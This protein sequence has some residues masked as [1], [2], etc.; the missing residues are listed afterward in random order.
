M[1]IIQ[2][3]ASLSKKPWSIVVIVCIGCLGSLK[4]EEF[5][6]EAC[7]SFGRAGNNYLMAGTKNMK[8]SFMYDHYSGVTWASQ[9][10]KSH[11]K[12]LLVRYIVQA[13]NNENVKPLPLVLYLSL[14]NQLK[15]GVELRMKMQLEQCSQVMLQLH[16]S[17]QQ[18]YCLIRCNLF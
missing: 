10:L 3:R 16:L 17:D 1:C 11:A 4:T 12:W 8:S 13:N 14:T 2:L 7:V 15:P 6:S 9:C 18:F 5:P